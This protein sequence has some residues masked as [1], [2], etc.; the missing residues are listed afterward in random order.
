VGKSVTQKL[1]S[2]ANHDSKVRHDQ[3]PGCVEISVVAQA[4]REFRLFL[5][6]KEW[7]PVHGRDIGIKVAE[8]GQ[9]KTGPA[10]RGQGSVI[11][12]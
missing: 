7:N 10:H 9:S 2:N 12:V 11:G 8:C 4:A 1:T 5:K 3:S 6:G